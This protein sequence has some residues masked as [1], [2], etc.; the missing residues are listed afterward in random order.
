MTWRTRWQVIYALNLYDIIEGK[1]DT[2]REYLRA[3]AP[4][5]NGE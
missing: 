5:L 2:Y 1:Q 3:P 4:L